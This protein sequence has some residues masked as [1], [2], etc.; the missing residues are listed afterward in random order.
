MS[1]LR[2]RRRMATRWA[3]YRN[4]YTLAVPRSDVGGKSAAQAIMFGYLNGSWRYIR[5]QCRKPGRR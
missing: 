1:R 2:R 4:H 3:R 5:R